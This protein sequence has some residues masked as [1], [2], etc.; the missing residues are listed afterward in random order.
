M[1]ARAGEAEVSLRDREVLAVVCDQVAEAVAAFR[2]S[3]R[4]QQSRAELVTAPEEDAP[5]VAP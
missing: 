5:A 2:L 4:L 3:E 1:T